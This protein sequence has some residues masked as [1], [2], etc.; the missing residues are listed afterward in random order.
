MLSAWMKTTLVLV[1]IFIIVMLGL[2]F[3]R[4]RLVPLQI[5]LTVLSHP[6]VV[7]SRYHNTQFFCTRR[8]KPT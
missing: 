2:A 4:Q 6:Q 8:T 7:V 1:T 3:S 5:E